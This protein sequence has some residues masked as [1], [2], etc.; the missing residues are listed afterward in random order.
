MNPHKLIDAYQPTENLRLGRRLS[1]RPA[2]DVL[3]VSRRQGFVHEG[4]DAVHRAWRVPQARLRHDVPELH[5]DARRAPQHARPRAPVVGAAAERSSERFVEERRSEGGARPV[6]VVQGVQVGV[7]DE[8]RP[9]DLPRGVSRALLRG[10][11]PSARGLCVRTDRQ[12]GRARIAHAAAGESGDE[13][14]GR[15]E[16][17]EAPASP[18]AAARDAQARHTELREMGALGERAGAGTERRAASARSFSGPTPST[19]TSTRRRAVRRSTCC[20]RR[21]RA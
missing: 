2:G 17:R 10:A 5:G 11:P 9:R 12:M 8:R 1:S 20:R 19:T 18:G 16:H 21:A 3:L 15:D 6:P 14:A 13:R 7:P 4:D